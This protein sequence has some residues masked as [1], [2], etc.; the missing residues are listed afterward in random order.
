MPEFK[1]VTKSEHENLGWMRPDGANFTFGLHFVPV[2]MSEFSSLI[3]E[4][5]VVFAKSREGFRLTAV[6]SLE[7]G[8]NWFVSSEGKWRGS[9]IPALLRACHF[10]LAGQKRR[11]LCVDQE[12]LTREGGEPLF[13]NQGNLSP[14]AQEKYDFLAKLEKNRNITDKAV[15]NLADAGVFSPWKLQEL[16]RVD[17]ATLNSLED[18]RFLELRQT[19]PLVYGHLYSLSRVEVLYRMQSRR[20]DEKRQAEELR[21]VLGWDEQQ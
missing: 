15:Q 6:M 11:L 21:Q 7:E 14:A 17:E 2:V 12:A 18:K 8:K 9:Y 13:D 1:P 3:H 10:L 4:L 16:Y 19:L 5:P 20:Q